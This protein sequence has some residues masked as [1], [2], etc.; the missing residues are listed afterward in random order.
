MLA[1]LFIIYLER[2][3]ERERES[4]VKARIPNKI[5]AMI[6]STVRTKKVQSGARK[7]RGQGYGRV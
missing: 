3:R 7:A 6:I 5:S 2:E 1:I 4:R